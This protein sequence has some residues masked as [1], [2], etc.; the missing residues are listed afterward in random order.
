MWNILKNLT[1]WMILYLVLAYFLR[2]P[3]FN[4][5]K[6]G[7][8][9]GIS[10]SLG[11]L[12]L[13]QFS[14]DI[15][16][17][18][19]IEQRLSD[20]KGID[21]I[22]LEIDN[23]IKMI[24]TPEK[25]TEKGAKLHKGVLLFGK[26]GTG[27]TL[28]A[29]AIAGE[30]NVNF[31]YCTGSQFDEMFVGLGAKRVRELFAEAKKNTPC[32]IFIDE[33]DTLLNKSRRFGHEHSSNRATINQLL[34]ELDGFEKTGDILVIGA[35]NNKDSLDSAAIRP[36]RFDKKIFVPVPDLGGRTDIFDYY[37]AKIAH[38]FCILYI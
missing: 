22:R 19:S 27:K 16:Y 6:D 36:G 4:K 34:A 14:F 32:I 13:S 25:Y 7:K 1:S 8:L 18:N 10:S 20:V 12:G 17:A 24:K 21:E 11:K 26:P 29:R 31:I 35:T 3:P 5:K 23:L 38:S 2:F 37:L 15:K 28:L 33:I 30:A 9:P